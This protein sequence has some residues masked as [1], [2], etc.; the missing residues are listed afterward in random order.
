MTSIFV[1]KLD[2]GVTEEEL[3]GL[4][5]QY[6]GVR[7]VHIATDRETG[8][9]RGFAFVEMFNDEEAKA[10]IEGLDGMAINGRNIAVKE[11]EDR[12]NQQ[13]KP[14]N[15]PQRPSSDQD[16]GSFKP[17]AESKSDDAPQ[18]AYGNPDDI[19]EIPSINIEPKRKKSHTKSK[20]SSE[21]DENKPKKHKMNAYKKSGKKNQFYDDDEEFDEDLNLFGDESDDELDLNEDY[22]D[23]LIN[24]DDEEYDDDYYDDSDEE[25]EW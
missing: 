3:K 6:G 23:Y 15:K 1:A 18:G 13:K 21:S 8:K 14:F 5:E 2:F 19:S 24:S 9:P 16:R 25:A 10:A 4:F 22:S 7:K 20:G 12:G 17:K 11:A